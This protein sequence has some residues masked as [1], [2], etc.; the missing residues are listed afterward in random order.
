MKNWKYI[1]DTRFWIMNYR[2][3][4]RV[5][6]IMIELLRDYDF[7]NISGHTAMLGG[8]VIWTSNYPYASMTLHDCNLRPS[9]RTIELAYRKLNNDKLKVI[10]EESRRR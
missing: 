3:D 6:E 5:D 10:L 7:E 9:R 4:K 2:Y 8:F 1:F